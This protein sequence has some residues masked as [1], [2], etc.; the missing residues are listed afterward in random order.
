MKKIFI[1][2]VGLFLIFSNLYSE[3]TKI[4]EKESIFDLIISSKTEEEICEYINNNKYSKLELNE[5]NSNG[6][7]PLYLAI[8]TGKVHVLE[9]LIKKGAK[10]NQITDLTIRDK[11]G[12]KILR[13]SP[14]L[15]AAW[16][17]DLN[18]LQFLL[19]KGSKNNIESDFIIPNGESSTYIRL[20]CP[21]DAAFYNRKKIDFNS[22][23]K[24]LA[25]KNIDY[26]HIHFSGHKWAYTRIKTYDLLKEYNFLEIK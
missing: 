9:L 25:S 16:K 5:K 7:T 24:I 18:C 19:E 6:Y 21:I 17:G 4:V 20:I 1:S 26:Q 2:L 15:Y 23:H 13:C 14:V 11:T 22:V 12:R 3:E 10:K 8:D